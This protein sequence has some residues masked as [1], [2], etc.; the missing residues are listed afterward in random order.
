MPCCKYVQ[1]IQTFSEINVLKACKV[2]KQTQVQSHT[3]LGLSIYSIW[4]KTRKYVVNAKGRSQVASLGFFQSSKDNNNGSQRQQNRKPR[5]R[6]IYPRSKVRLSSFA[7]QLCLYSCFY[8]Q[9]QSLRQNTMT[10][11]PTVLE[12]AE[13]SLCF[14][15]HMHAIISRVLYIF[16]PFLKTISLFSRRFFQKILSLCMV[17]IQ[18]RFLIKNV[19]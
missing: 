1:K 12:F 4:L 13:F 8:H 16:T 14:T 7:Q 18:E 2:N 19:L 10:I 6:T 9:T 15:Y 5:P 3:Y 17:S 11:L